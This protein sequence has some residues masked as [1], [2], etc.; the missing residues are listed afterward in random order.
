MQTEGTSGVWRTGWVSGHRLHAEVQDFSREHGLSR[1]TGWSGDA[2]MT[3]VTCCARGTG[4]LEVRAWF[5][6]QAGLGVRLV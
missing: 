2:E 5:E 1:D 3:G 6:A 4:A